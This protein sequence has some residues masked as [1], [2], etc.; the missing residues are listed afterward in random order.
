MKMLGIVQEDDKEYIE[1]YKARPGDVK[2][3]DYNNDGVINANDRHYLGDRNPLFTMNFNN[4]LNYKG[5]GL[6]ISF[7]WTAGNDE[8]FLGRNPYG[9]MV[10]TGIGSNAQLKNVTPYTIE[11]PNNEFPRVN[12]TNGLSYQF[13]ENRE[14]IKLK[15]ISL[16][17]TLNSRQLTRLGLNSAKLYISSNNLLTFSK[18]TG[19]DPEDGGF[20][21]AQPG[22]NYNWSYPV[23]RTFALGTTISF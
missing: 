7:K 6:Y 8:H 23:L 12:W 11:N 5:F 21:A 4:T 18:W 16:S 2:F 10:S 9:T 19:L 3:L 15:D 1:K 22:S 20:I 13:W 17:Y 14:F